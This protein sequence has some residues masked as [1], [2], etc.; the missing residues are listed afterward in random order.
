VAAKLMLL[1]HQEPNKPAETREK[2]SEDHLA[3]IIGSFNCVLYDYDTRTCVLAQI[4]AY[5]AD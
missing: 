5:L 1:S 2:S 4:I 3:K